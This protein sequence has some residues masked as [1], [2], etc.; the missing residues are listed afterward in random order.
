MTQGYYAGISGIQTHQYGIDVVSDNL[1]NMSTTGY[2]SVG[3]EFADLFSKAVASG[4]K[5]PTANDIGHGV[6]LQAT[7]LQLGQGAIL[8]S[9]RFN[10]L[11]LEGRGWFGVTSKGD[12]YYTRDGHFLFDT[13]E[14]VPGDV[15]SSFARLVTSDGKYVSGTMLTNFTYDGNFDYGDITGDS[16]AF[17]LNTPVSDVPLAAVQSQGKIEFPTRLAYPV[18]PTTEAS[19]FG[20]LGVD[21]EIRSMSADAISASNEHNRIKLVFTQSAIQPAEG[22][23]WDVAATVTTNDGSIVYDTQNGQAVFDASGLLSSFNIA[24]LNNDG[25]PVAISLENN[26]GGVISTNGVGVSGS[27]QSNG[28]SGGTLTNYGI[29]TNGV[30]VAEFSNGLQSAIGRVAVYHFQN[31]Q[32]L[33]R[34]NGT[35]FRESSN[36]GAPMFFTDANGNAITGATVRSGTLEASNVRMD[37]GLTDMIIMQRAYQANAKTITTVDEMIQKA[38]QMRR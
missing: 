15:N 1:A 26:N 37:V 34:E 19:F 28:I 30:I 22:S 2:K 11:S 9:D 38:L 7:A 18:S 5:M 17:V 21:N 25:T 12:D 24:S 8:P 6:R 14:Q 4:G 13:N 33:S 16:G 23:A 27:S 36:S 35:Y 32:G 31:D 10:D 29:D 20:N 3:T